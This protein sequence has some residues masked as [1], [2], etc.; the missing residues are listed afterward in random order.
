M[1]SR[2]DSCKGEDVDELDDD[3]EFVGECSTR[4][5][6]FVSECVVSGV[7][8]DPLSEGEIEETTHKR[9][10]CH[11]DVLVS[12]VASV[13]NLPYD[14]D[15]SHHDG[16]HGKDKQC[17]SGMVLIIKECHAMVYSFFIIYK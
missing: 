10:D 1:I 3:V 11:D 6:E 9:T 5:T 14:G 8:P 17:E 16:E 15:D 2:N 12:N 13:N 4:E 7:S